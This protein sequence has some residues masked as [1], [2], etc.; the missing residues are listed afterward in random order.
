MASKKNNP[1]HLGFGRLMLWKSSDIAAAALNVI[2]LTYLSVYCS[3]T[4]GLDITLVGTI[5]M[6]SKIIDAFT[7]IFAGWLVDNTHTKWGKGR[8]YEIA[9]VGMMLC[10]LGLF[11]GNPAWSEKVKIAWVFCMYTLVFSIFSTLRN[12]AANP[13][14]IRHFSN[15]NVLITKVASFGGIIT[16]AGSMIVSMTFPIVMYKLATSAAGWT[17]TVAIFIIPLTLIAVLRFIFCKEDPSV[18][19]DASQFQ[20]V[21]LNEIFAMFRKNKYVW[22]YAIIML[23]FN[24]STALGGATY[25]YKYIIGNMGLMSITS[26][27][28]FVLLPVMFTFPFL[29][30]KFGSMG[31]MIGTFACIGVVGWL[32]A[33]VGGSNL[34][35]VLLGG[36]LGSFAV[37]PLSYYP[38]LFIMRIC[39]Y[40]EMVG[41]PR[42]DGSANILANFM[43]KL[44]GALGSFIT[45]ALLGA[46]GYI[47][48]E[49]VTTQPDAVLLMIRVDFA[50]VPAILMVIIAI[51][52]FAFSKL[53]TKEIPAWEAQKKAAQAAAE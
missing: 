29:M 16:M 13:Y 44:G 31:K 40:N 35:M 45:G 37:L 14:T 9:I 2:V 32:I 53:E 17:T 3:D 10:S 36:M 51:C 4:L 34:P 11:A 1:D 49:G 38:V 33:F 25:Y 47:S 22:I 23:C 30:K 18:D 41:L 15:N 48:A 24:I 6:A 27:F 42:M 20:P 28:S 8:P 5:L 46:V 12:A 39:T 19:G 7:D 50:I 21:R 52:A 26:V 43:T